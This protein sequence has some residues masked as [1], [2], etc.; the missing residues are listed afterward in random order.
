MAT[1]LVRVELH[2]ASGKDYDVLHVAMERVGFS[3]TIVSDTGVRYHLPTAEYEA[4]G[5]HTREEVLE[6]AKGAA[7]TTGKKF[8][9]IVTQSAGQS[10]SGLPQVTDRNR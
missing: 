10:W 1:F 2:G 5:N 7:G 8:G 9:V 4:V 6:A 3:R